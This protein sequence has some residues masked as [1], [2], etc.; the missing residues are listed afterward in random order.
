MTVW[1]IG[2]IVLS[3]LLFFLLFILPPL[4]LRMI[5]SR[6]LAAA[7]RQAQGI[8]DA[9]G[10]GLE[11]RAQ[12]GPTRVTVLIENHKDE[13][14][15]DL[16]AEHGL[17]F[18][19]ERDGRK[20][21]FDTG[22]SGAVVG[23]A[24]KLGIDLAEI[25]TIILSHGHYDHGGGLAAV[26]RI[27]SQAP[28]YVGKNATEGRYA[29]VL[30]YSSKWIG[31]DRKL[32]D[33]FS[34]RFRFVNALRDLGDGFFILTDLKGPHPIPAGNKA[35][36]R[37]DDGQLVQDTFED[38]IAL[39]IK[40]TDGIVVVTGCS[41][42]GILNIVEA[43]KKQFPSAPL[44]AVLGG[45]HLIDPRFASMSEKSGDVRELAEKLLES[46]AGWFATGHCTGVP[47]FTALKS[48]MGDKLDY[49]STGSRFTV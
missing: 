41:H 34:Y 3:A 10:P 16:E 42:N 18:C 32:I 19:F 38:E 39:V 23:N 31:L 4:R 12:G 2:T 48:V 7:Q 43:A 36:H 1:I 6:N 47:A 28:A 35:L 8:I 33:S 11:K 22:T 17:S 45:F 14:L 30:W 21:L 24:K 27:N 29:C 13:K 20:I 46:G 26:L 49:L 40:D 15:T 5:R 37:D 44:K 25:D 9:S